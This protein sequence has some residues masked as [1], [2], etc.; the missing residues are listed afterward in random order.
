MP[1]SDQLSYTSQEM[2]T[3]TKYEMQVSAQQSIIDSMSEE[4]TNE[5][6]QFAANLHTERLFAK[7]NMQR[8]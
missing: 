4:L 3:R 5:Q 6:A 2:L 8:L 1:R 7:T